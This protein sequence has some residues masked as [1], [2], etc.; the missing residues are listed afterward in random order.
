[1]PYAIC[2][3]LRLWYPTNPPP[4]PLKTF[5]KPAALSSSLASPSRSVDISTADVISKTPKVER[6][7]TATA[8]GA[9]SNTTSHLTLLSNTSGCV[10]SGSK[11]VPNKPCVTVWVVD[12]RL[13]SRKNPNRRVGFISGN[14]PRRYP[15]V[16]A[17]SGVIRKKNSSAAKYKETPPPRNAGTTQNFPICLFPTANARPST[18]PGMPTNASCSN[19]PGFNPEPST[20]TPMKRKA[21]STVK[22]F[23]PDNTL[24]APEVRTYPVP[25]RKPPVTG[26]G[27][28]L[29]K[30][31]SLYLPSKL[32]ST[33]VATV[34]KI[35]A[36]SSVGNLAVS[37][38]PSVE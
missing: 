4:R 10:K 1:M 36:A 16:N 20:D 22:A 30:F 17:S 38:M 19:H 9:C 15:R 21:F 34:V 2:V 33:P 35:I 3:E 24:N 11:D 6:P 8:P 37:S 13:E 27:K 23:P 12:P 14:G 32:I 29:T 18:M 26:D 28:S 5:A 7:N 31:P 25:A